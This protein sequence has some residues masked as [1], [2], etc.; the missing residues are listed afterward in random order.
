[1]K[2]RYWIGCLLAVAGLTGCATYTDDYRGGLTTAAGTVTNTVAYVGE[3]IT[4]EEHLS[5]LQDLDLFDVGDLIVGMPT[6]ATNCY[7]PCP[8]WTA[9][10]EAGQEAEIAEP[11][12]LQEAR[13]SALVAIAEDVRAEESLPEADPALAQEHLNAI[14]R[15]RVVVVGD[16]VL[17]AAEASTS[18]YNL[19]CAEDEARA[20]EENSARAAELLEIASRASGL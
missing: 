5:R 1:M 14:A 19:P 15:L 12:D 6:M 18:C 11:R 13:L 9:M 3:D 10:D 20:G 17:T 16:L 8:E 2:L 7:G 4:A